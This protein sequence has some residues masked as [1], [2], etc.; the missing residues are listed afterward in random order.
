M[1]LSRGHSQ[2]PAAE[3]TTGDGSL[4]SVL[5]EAECSVAALRKLD[6]RLT[7]NLVER[8]GIFLVAHQRYRD[9]RAPQSTDALQRLERVKNHSV[10]AFHIRAACPCS[11]SVEAHEP[12]AFTF[13]HRVEMT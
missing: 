6:Q 8:S 4:P 12:F 2:L 5:L 3:A 1:R 9:P 13:E 10:P 7:G 11:Q